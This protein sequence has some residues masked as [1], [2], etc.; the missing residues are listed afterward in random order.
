MAWIGWHNPINDLIEPVAAF[1]D[2]AGYLRGISVYASDRPEGR[3]PS[4]TALR[5][6]RVSVCNDYASDPRTL[7]WRE[8][9]AEHGIRASISLPVRAGNTPIAVLS[10]YASTSFFFGDKEIALL[11]EAAG[12]ISFALDNLERDA[13]REHAEAALRASESRYR[14]MFENSLDGFLLTVSDGGILSANSSAC[15]IFGRTEKELVGGG[16]GLVA[17]PDDPRLGTLLEQ[18]ARTGR[19]AG[20]LTLVRSD[21]SRFEAEIASVMFDTDDGA[22]TSMVIR[23]ITERRRT[24][25]HIRQQAELIDKADEAIVA[26]DLDGRITFWSQGAERLFGWKSAE[27]IGQPMNDVLALR[28]VV[29][30]TPPLPTRL[31]TSGVW[32]GEVRSQ[33]RA[34]GALMIETSITILRD[35]AGQPTGRLSISTD[36]TEKKKLEERFLHAQ[37]LENL[38]M[39]ASGVAHDLNNVL[40]P[41]V[42]A[43]PMLRPSLTGERD[44]KILTT[45]ERSAERGA[46]L[47]KQILG[48]AR[49]TTGELR[50]TQVKH[51]ARD[52]I[53]VIEET[54]PKSVQFEHHIPS[55]LWPVIGNPTQIHQILLN[56]CVN[57]RDAMPAG[58]TLRLTA[59]NRRLDAAQAAAWPDARPGA[60]LVLEVADTGGGIAPEVLARI[61]EPF[62]TTKAAGKGTGLGLSTVR[63]IVATHRGFVTLET[64]VE[65][66]TTFSVYLPASLDEA[67]A[68]KAPSLEAPAGRGEY[69]LV[70]DD[71]LAIRETVSA[72]LTKKNY[73]VA[74]A[75]NG[76]EAIDYFTK[77]S[78]E[79]VLLIT[80]MDMP[81]I[82]GAALARTLLQMQP[83][84]R[85]VAISGLPQA[86]HNSPDIQTTRKLAHAFLQKP[87]TAETL[88]VT[89]HELL[90]VPPPN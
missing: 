37:R 1:G 89:V 30:D 60:W 53:G 78:N 14:A 82:G 66:G 77:H 33:N 79:I 87:F 24:E 6:N 68:S 49:S 51:L 74:C 48:F 8:R 13:Q 90:R 40:A 25:Q 27:T 47:V 86:L 5:E 29:G 21:G 46:G 75:G 58:G 88:V 31:P 42:F 72:V 64:K 18:R 16:L 70:V 23:D 80:D 85:I 32:R 4:G 7:P 34:G 28:S 54:F 36:I 62:F 84:L 15:R 81:L 57:A 39:L 67:T 38:G 50:P 11:E 44:L 73:H 10:V 35:N 45:L 71:D 19:A 55:D 9:A 22:R 20:E 65:R 59:M 61:W 52:I 69:I 76:V 63:G 26:S 2:E 3:G 17:A 41:I 83:A 12:E 43:A 56:L